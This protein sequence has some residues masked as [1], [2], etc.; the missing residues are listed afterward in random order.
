[1][2]IPVPISPVDVTL[3]ADES[4]TFEMVDSAKYNGPAKVRYRRQGTTPWTEQTADIYAPTKA[5]YTIPGGL[6][7]DDW[8]WQAGDQ[9]GFTTGWSPSAFFTLADR[10]SA[11]ALPTIVA[12]EPVETVTITGLT[13]TTLVLALGLTPGS[14]GFYVRTVPITA[15]SMD[16]DISFPSATNGQTVY[17]TAFQQGAAPTSPVST[18]EIDVAYVGPVAPT[19]AVTTLTDGGPVALRVT[20]THPAPGGGE[21]AAVE[22]DIE[23]QQTV[24]GLVWSDDAGTPDAWDRVAS[25]RVEAGGTVRVGQVLAAIT[26]DYDDYDLANRQTVRYRARAISNTGAETAGDWSEA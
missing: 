15:E 5:R 9:T 8:E 20:P 26:D 7:D 19:V 16:L 11:P 13:G 18:Q 2:G 23:R 22:V 24:D 3:A 17:L 10:L 21:P 14:G 6:S 12:N 4:L 25:T 1:M